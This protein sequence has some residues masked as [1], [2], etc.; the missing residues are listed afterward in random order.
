MKRN[1]IFEVA[2]LITLFLL[3]LIVVFPYFH[4][5]YFPT[6]D[7]EWAVVRLADMFRT[8]RDGQFPARFS[9]ALN[10]GYGYPLFNFAY[11]LPYYLGLLFYIP[12]HSFIMS[13]KAM[14]VLSVFASAFLMYFASKELWKSHLSGFVSAILYIFLPY[15]MIDLY[16]RGSLGEN[17]SFVLFPLILL[18]SLKLFSSPFN[19]F[20]V[21]VLAIAVGSLVVTHNI[22]TVLFM[23]VLLAFVGTRIVS[24]KRFDVLQSFG[25]SIVI[26]IFLSAFFWIPALFE[27]NNILLSVKPIADRSLYF[28]NLPQLLIPSFGY[29]PPLE[30]GG[31]SY[32]LG[33]A[34]AITVA[35]SILFLIVTCIKFRLTLTPQKRYF[36]VLMGI[37]AI[38]FL[39]LFSFTQIIWQNVPLLKEI[40]YPWTFLSQLGL[41]TALLAGFL[42]TQG[43][44]L[45]FSM[46]V[47]AVGAIVLVLPY[48]KPEYFNDRTDEF[49]MTNE[50]TTT[51]SDELM[52]LWV[53][54]FP[55]SRHP[56]KVE[57]VSGDAIIENIQST[58]KSTT[59]VYKATIPSQIRVNTIYY[60]GWNAFIERDS[61]PINYNNAK[62]VM[63]IDAEP[64]GQSRVMFYFSETLL[65]MSANYLTIFGI[66]VLLFI[67][68]RPM[69]SFKR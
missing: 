57:V 7:G 47:A 54:D 53:K 28:V 2:A 64:T 31:F 18:L 20:T 14:F 22:M 13:I 4:A 25:L 58:S 51:S 9:G 68:L 35:I 44:L 63:T 34:Q 30:K 33:M 11:P 27:K 24:E 59:F 21:S 12:F 37:Y 66:L 62:G 10:F 69:L 17:I 42:V 52:P 61:V 55:K 45:R 48:A 67:L 6:H 19:R 26:G 5:G 50:A 49:Y 56:G 43:K 32:Q 40:N 8:I 65:R 15:R 16:V 60:P 29:A 38:C 41:L 46:L 39:M 36:V 3:C 1:I 23:P